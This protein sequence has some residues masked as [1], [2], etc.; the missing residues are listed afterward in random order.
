LK[1]FGDEKRGGGFRQRGLHVT[2]LMRLRSNVRLRVSLCNSF[3]L[4]RAR[5]SEE[6][7]KM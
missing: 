5:T 2:N 7:E 3:L 6:Y 1:L 4:E